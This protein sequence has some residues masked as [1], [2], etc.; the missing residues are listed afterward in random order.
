M[1]Y[2]PPTPSSKASKT[3]MPYSLQ[4]RVDSTTSWFIQREDYDMNSNTSQTK[5]LLQLCVGDKDGIFLPMLDA[6]I[7]MRCAPRKSGCVIRSM[8][9]S[10]DQVQELAFLTT[11]PPSPDN[12][13]A[14]GIQMIGPQ[15]SSCNIYSAPKRRRLDLS[16][17]TLMMIDPEHSS[18]NVYSTPKRKNSDGMTSPLPVHRIF[19]IS[20]SHQYHEISAAVTQKLSIPDCL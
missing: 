11:I 14:T 20:P 2:I 9:V 5:T 4:R 1:N 13:E 7:Q 16:K 3:S 17:A 10:E 19:R 6:P 15:Y 8:P 18:C 12:A